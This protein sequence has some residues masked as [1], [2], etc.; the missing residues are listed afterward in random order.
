MTFFDT[1]TAGSATITNTGVRDSST[2]STAGSATI[3]NN[4]QYLAFLDASTAGSA[5]ITNNVS[6]P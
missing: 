5:T 3:T 1:S 6:V 4:G 2:R